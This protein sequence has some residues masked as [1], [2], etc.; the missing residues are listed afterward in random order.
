M[1]KFICS[2]CGSAQ[3]EE[4]WANW[5]DVNAEKINDDAPGRAELYSDTNWCGDC[6]EHPPHLVEIFGRPDEAGN[7]M[8]LTVADGEPVTRL[9]G[10]GVYP[11]GS[12]LGANYE[13][14]DGIVLSRADATGLGIY[15]G[16]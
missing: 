2:V 14:P 11:V 8:V 7:I 15:I 1:M 5:Y 3:V 12:A 13:H 6:Q 10:S 9:T 4:F 16:E